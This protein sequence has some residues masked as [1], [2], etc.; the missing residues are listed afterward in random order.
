[1]FPAYLHTQHKL[2]CNSQPPK[3][4]GRGYD[5]QDIHETA[6]DQSNKTPEMLEALA[7]LE[8]FILKVA[9]EHR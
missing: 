6:Y 5:R 8:A 3:E 1:L 2:K 7:K 4:Q 9:A